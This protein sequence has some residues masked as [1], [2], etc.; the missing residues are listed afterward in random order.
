MDVLSLVS[1]VLLWALGLSLAFLVLGLLRA[2]A[3]VTWRLEQL[4]ATTPS[5]IGRSGLKKGTRAP[6]FRL[7]SVQGTEVSLLDYADSKLFLVF[8]QSGCG[9]CKNIVPELNRIQALGGI[10]VLVIHKGDLEASRKWTSD[11]QA[12]FPV[13]AQEDW[14]VSKR[15][16]VFATPFAFVIDTTGVIV[17]KGIINNKEHVSFVLSGAATWKSSSEATEGELVAA[18]TVEV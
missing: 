12:R 17:S 16:Q 5:R 15:Y 10:Q 9:P 1:Q 3:L 7:P 6:D 18:K 8:M 4:E 11:L 2:L 14:T 13:L